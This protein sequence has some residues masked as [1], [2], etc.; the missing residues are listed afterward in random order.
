M[1][2]QYTDVINHTHR[3]LSE[4]LL[5]LPTYGRRY[6]GTAN[7][8]KHDNS[9]RE[10]TCVSATAA[11]VVYDPCKALVVVRMM[12]ILT[13]QI[14]ST[15]KPSRLL[16]HWNPSCYALLSYRMLSSQNFQDCRIQ[17]W[18][19]FVNGQTL[20]VYCCLLRNLMHMLYDGVS[21]ILCCSPC[22]KP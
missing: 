15:A 16:S 14:E 9:K 4:R 8:S 20:G 17:Q 21:I 3:P 19:H 7:S 11:G 5:S 10:N 22:W 1:S 13:I 6:S 2:L 12:R 18:L